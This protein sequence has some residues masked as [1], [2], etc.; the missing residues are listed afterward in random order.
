VTANTEYDGRSGSTL[1][2]EQ[3]SIGDYLEIK[4]Y[5]SVDGSLIAVRVKMEDEYNDHHGHEVEIFGKIDDIIDNKIVIGSWEFIVNEHT[6]IMNKNKILISFSELK[7]NDRVEVKAYKQSDGSFLAV[8][9]KFE[10]NSG[11]DDN[12]EIEI[13]AQI[14]AIDASSITVRGLN[15]SYDQNTVFLDHNRMSADVSSFTVGML[16]EIKGNRNSDGKYYASRVKIE[17]FF[18]NQ[19]ELKGFIDE[20]TDSYI[21]VNSIKFQVNGST[22]VLDNLNNQIDY[23]SLVMDQLVEIKGYKTGNSDLTAVRIK[24]EDGND[25][26]VYGSISEITP[27]HFEL[28]GLVINVDNS[29]I[30]LNHN[31]QNISY[32]DLQVGYFVEV[33]YIVSQGG[34]AKALKV[35]IEDRPGFLTVIGSIGSV[36]NSNI[37]VELSDFQIN[38][39]TVVI[40][41]SYNIISVS[42]LR[43]GEDVSLWIDASVSSNPL[44][45]Q[46]QSKVSSVTSADPEALIVSTFELHQNYPNPFNPT[47]NITFSMQNNDFVSLKVFNAIGQEVKTLL[48]ENMSAGTHT[49]AFNASELT[50]GVYFYRL[51]SGKSVSIKKM[52]LMK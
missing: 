18:N 38:E 27:T 25:I 47:T 17:D 29:T 15:F 3:I 50:S 31:N 12:S 30:F 6:I 21:I 22:V 20:I 44:V 5:K 23:N 16:V 10:D 24:I 28:D 7:V 42:D 41:K 40:D 2:F 49:V 32:S 8:R 39:S 34:S 33:K 51:E 35:K 46:I 36:N 37:Q 52:I 14:E 45:L 26:E 19:V 1:S 43:P 9:I 48:N 13:K 4:S 11:Y